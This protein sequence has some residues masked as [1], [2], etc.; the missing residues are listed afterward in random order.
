[1]GLSIL[2]GAI[3][4]FGSGFFLVF[5]NFSYFYKFAMTVTVTVSFSYFAAVLTFGAACH[6]IGPERDQ[7]NPFVLCKKCKKKEESDGVE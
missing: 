7:G 2:S 4:T 6:V 1:M 3:T 5:A